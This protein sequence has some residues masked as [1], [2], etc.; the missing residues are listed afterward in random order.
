MATP[1]IT[2]RPHKRRGRRP[3]NRK[4]ANGSKRKGTEPTRLNGPGRTGPPAHQEATAQAQR[5]VRRTEAL[6]MYVD[7][8]IPMAAIARQ[9]N[10][11][12][13]TVCLDIHAAL[14]ELRAQRADTIE[15]GR[16][17]E[18]ARLDAA[19]RA[20]LPLLHGQ[21]PSRAVVRGRR[22]VQVPDPERATMQL[23]A[24]ARVVSSGAARRQVLGIDAPVKVA[25]TD[26]GGGRPYL[27]ASLAELE[28]LV[29]S[30]FAALG[31]APAAYRPARA[32][33]GPPGGL[34]DAQVHASPT[35]APGG[36]STNGHGGGS[37]GG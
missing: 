1:K 14:D 2:H 21:M 17:L 23:K 32:E 20:V 30:R 35:G 22:V 34:P 31:V 16:T 33:I 36:P 37:H 5:E 12:V 26:P 13:K 3:G 25:P 4:A 28:A 29:L 8:R 10:V 27:A 18:V 24:H 19:D 11:N 7:L 15:R 9:L 6:R